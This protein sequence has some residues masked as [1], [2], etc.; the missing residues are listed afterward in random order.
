MN[1]DLLAA[2]DENCAHRS[3]CFDADTSEDAAARVALVDL[4]T[5]KNA[6][7]ALRPHWAQG[8]T[9]DS[10]AAQTATAALADIWELLGV[11]NQTAAM[12]ALRRLVENA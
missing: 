5:R 3:G 4:I 2:W 1:I 10:I 9:D 8:Y 12:Q 11:D 7:E 6:L